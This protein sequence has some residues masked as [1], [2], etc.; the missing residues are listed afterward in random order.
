MRVLLKVSFLSSLAALLHVSILGP[1]AFL[2]ASLK[3]SQEAFENYPSRHGERFTTHESMPGIVSKLLVLSK[4]Q[5][6]EKSLVNCEESRDN[7]YTS[8]IA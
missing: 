6:G 8:T 3:V 7:K 2:D 1:G 5:G 4:F